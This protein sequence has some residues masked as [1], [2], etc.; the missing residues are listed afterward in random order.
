[1]NELLLKTINEPN[2]LVVLF[3]FEEVNLHLD[4]YINIFVTLQTN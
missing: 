1:M 2:S 3:E 4:I